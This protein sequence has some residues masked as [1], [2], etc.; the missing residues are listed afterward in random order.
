MYLIIF[1]QPFFS[2]CTSE[3][4]YTFFFTPQG[5]LF[6][7]PWAI[8]TISLAPWELFFTLKFFFSTQG[9]FYNQI[10]IKTTQP[11][12]ALQPFFHTEGEFFPPWCISPLYF[13]TPGYFNPMGIFFSPSP[14]CFFTPSQLCLSPARAGD[15]VV[16]DGAQGR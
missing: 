15:T 16:D 13:F 11:G 10:F 7:T 1:L 5:V 8:F 9:Y 6:P 3:G 2:F 14:G 12:V 4:I